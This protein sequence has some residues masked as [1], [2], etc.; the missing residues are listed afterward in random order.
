[1]PSA[2]GLHQSHTIETVF[3]DAEGRFEQSNQWVPLGCAAEYVLPTNQLRVGGDVVAES[4]NP[5]KGSRDS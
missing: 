4:V 2:R 1:M 3:A 5:L